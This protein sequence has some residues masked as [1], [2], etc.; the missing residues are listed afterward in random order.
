MTSSPTENTTPLDDILEAS[1]YE[2]EPLYRDNVK[3][4]YYLKKKGE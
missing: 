4:G 1:G 2:L 3:Q